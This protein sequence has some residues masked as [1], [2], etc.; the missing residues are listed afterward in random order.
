VGLQSQGALER[1]GAPPEVEGVYGMRGTKFGG[2]SQGQSFLEYG[3][4]ILFVV[5]AVVGA[6][7]LLG[8]AISNIFAQVPSS[9]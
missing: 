7:V 5:L 1:G 8:P 9:L 3:L 4:I 6:L 2:A